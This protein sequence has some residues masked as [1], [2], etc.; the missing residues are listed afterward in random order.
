MIESNIYCVKKGQTCIPTPFTMC[1]IVAPPSESTHL[2]HHLRG[3]VVNR[4]T[5][6]ICCDSAINIKYFVSIGMFAY[7]NRFRDI[8]VHQNYFLIQ[9][10]KPPLCQNRQKAELNILQNQ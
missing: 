3:F 6:G 1:A 8:F 9:Y 10:N 5:L 4:A 7:K 2:W